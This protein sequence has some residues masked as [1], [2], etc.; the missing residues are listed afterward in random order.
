M[1]NQ[2]ALARAVL[3]FRDSS[4]IRF[5]NKLGRSRVAEP[6]AAAPLHD[7]P[8]RLREIEAI[9]SR[10]RPDFVRILRTFRIP[11]EDARDLVQNVYVTFLEKSDS[12]ADPERWMIGALRR[13]CLHFLRTER[14][15]LYEAIDDALLD[16]VVCTD[17]VPQERESLL[18]ALARRIRDLG[19]RCRELLRLRFRLGC[20][21]FETADQLRLRPSSIGTLEKRCLAALSERLLATEP[22]E[23]SA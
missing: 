5:G 1:A 6:Y 11:S 17:V 3:A 19:E 20:D 23:K 15:K 21:R 18:A 22:Y 10:V 12:V 16:L 8:P 2:D 4:T 7:V 13:E 9:V 14:H